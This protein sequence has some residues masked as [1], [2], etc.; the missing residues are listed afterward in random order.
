MQN[1]LNPCFNGILKYEIRKKVKLGVRRLNP[2]F[3]GILK[4]SL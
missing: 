1:C 4:Y 3:N 2:C